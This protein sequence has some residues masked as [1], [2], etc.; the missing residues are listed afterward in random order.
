MYLLHPQEP[1]QKVTHCSSDP[2]V[3]RLVSW[4]QQQHKIAASFVY[5]LSGL[6]GSINPILSCL[7]FTTFVT[8][9]M[10]YPGR[11]PPAFLKISQHTRKQNKLLFSNRSPHTEHS[12]IC[13]FFYPSFFL[14]NFSLACTW[15]LSFS[16]ASAP[17]ST[18]ACSSSFSVTWKT[19]LL[20]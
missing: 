19:T 17:W 16:N 5:T 7:E 2:P 13:F 10:I 12:L 6:R 11:W 3:L 1:K 15:V 8:N 9:L 14:L 18:P 4:V 20:K